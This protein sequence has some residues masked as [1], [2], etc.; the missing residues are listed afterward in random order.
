MATAPKNPKIPKNVAGRNVAGAARVVGG[1]I[2]AGENVG[3][4]GGMFDVLAPVETAL[5]F[6]AGAVGTATFLAPHALGVTSKVAS[7]MG[8]TDLVSKIDNFTSEWHPEARS[9]AEI[10][11]NTATR[12]EHVGNVAFTLGAGVSSYQ[13]AKSFAEQLDALKH[14]I[15][16]IKGG[17]AKNISTMSAL[18]APIPKSLQPARDHLLKEHAVRGVA[19]VAGLVAMILAVRAK[20]NVGHA[21]FFAPMIVDMGANALLGETF[22]PVYAEMKNAYQAAQASG[23]E[24]PSEAYAKFVFET[25]PELHRRGEVGQQVALKVGEQYA[26]EKADPGAILREI[27]SGQFME[28]VKGLIA[29]A[30]AEHAAMVQAQ[31]AKEAEAKAEQAHPA[32]DNKPSMVA[33]LS[34]EQPA[35]PVLGK[36]TQ[37]LT[38]QAVH[39]LTDIRNYP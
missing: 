35:R 34:G 32:A 6:G 23:Q 17:D 33:R 27:D 15:A 3:R 31:K 28:R 37:N 21:A 16:D 38:Q 20:K 22:L 36:H 12:L 5:G 26:H 2:A 8:K 9:E 4:A 39:E 30:E 11:T 14:A 19:Q 29:E 24:L 1:D 7:K 18:F 13:V 25:S 10:A